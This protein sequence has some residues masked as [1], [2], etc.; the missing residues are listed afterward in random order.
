MVQTW[1]MSCRLQ[2][3]PPVRIVSPSITPADSADPVG[4][5]ENFDMDLAKVLC[6]VSV[7]PSLVTPLVEE[8]AVSWWD[9]G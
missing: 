5:V 2:C 9:S 3:Y 4:G 7:L 1:K 8:E 6:D